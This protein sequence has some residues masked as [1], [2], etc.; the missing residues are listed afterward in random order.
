[1]GP[2]HRLLL[3]PGSRGPVPSLGC[4]ADALLPLSSQEEGETPILLR[5]SPSLD[6][7]LFSVYG[8]VQTHPGVGPGRQI[9]EEIVAR[10]KETE[11]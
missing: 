6:L 10:E 2:R 4:A 11:T 7:K 9:S 1:M 5:E 8:R 3:D